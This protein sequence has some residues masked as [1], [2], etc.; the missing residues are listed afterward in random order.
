VRAAAALAQW[1]QQ[2]ARL[3]SVESDKCRKL[4]AALAAALTTAPAQPTSAPLAEGAEIERLRQELAALRSALP[5]RDREIAQLR[6]Q[7]TQQ[8]ALQESEAAQA[9]QAGMAEDA[10]RIEAL[11]ANARAE[12]QDDIA[13]ATARAENAERML[14]EAQGAP[15]AEV[16]RWDDGYVDG[17]RR[18][19]STLRAALVNREVELG[20]ARAALDQARVHQ[21]VQRPG[22]APIRRFAGPGEEPEGAPASAKS[23]FM[24]DFAIMAC[25]LGPVVLAYPYLAGYLPDGVRSGISTVTGGLL[26]VRMEP[27]PA[28][29]VAVAAPAPAPVA[30]RPRTT[31]T[32]TA[33]V[34][35]TPAVKGTILATLPRDFVVV[36][37]KTNGNWT[38][39]EIP[40][41]D[42]TSKPQQ[43]W[44]FNTYLKSA[45]SS[46]KPASPAVKPGSVSTPAEPVRASTA[47]KSAS[48]AVKPD[49]ASVEPERAAAA[50][51]PENTSAAVEPESAAAE[52]AK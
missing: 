52:P 31:V 25:I 28:P 14:A 43:G 26:S 41:K 21:V 35:E 5:E 11:V 17:L 39:I 49:S 13:A 3:L 22:N 29:R 50:V 37:L 24:R 20:H 34:R 7:M 47:V 4:E 40:A 48:S 12:L 36:V 45:A 44:V 42:A 38:Q 27:A 46:A 19:I 51:K 30:Q 32:R 33:N 9:A 23:T 8:R 15:A 1:Q 16:P 6:D 2:S 10:A 18:D